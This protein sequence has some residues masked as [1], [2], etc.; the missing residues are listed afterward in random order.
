MYPPEIASTAASCAQAEEE[1][2]DCYFALKTFENSSDVKV[3]AAANLELAVLALQHGLV[4]QAQE[5]IARASELNPD[6]PFIEL[7]HGWILLS[8]GK[9]KKARETFDH[10]LYLSADFEYVSSAKL[11]A[12]LAWYFGGN[13]EKAAEQ[14][15]YLYVSNPYAISFVSY[16]LVKI[17]FQNTRPRTDG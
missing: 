15:Q 14:F 2:E 8:A 1:E 4:K 17:H 5:H 3:A 12:A 9:Y 13:K 10:L 6:D 16:M 11:G 7:T